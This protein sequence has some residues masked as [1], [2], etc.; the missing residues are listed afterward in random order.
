ML[1]WENDAKQRYYTVQVQIDLFG[2]S[3]VCCFWGGVHSRRGG[4]RD[5][6]ARRAGDVQSKLSEIAAARAKRGYRPA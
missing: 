1:R 2:D 3:V 4:H 6:P 5:F